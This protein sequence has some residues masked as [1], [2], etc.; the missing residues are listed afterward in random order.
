MVR[1]TPDV[2]LSS[3]RGLQLTPSGLLT[4]QRVRLASLRVRR[5]VATVLVCLAC[6]RADAQ[7]LTF[8]RDIAPIVFARCAPCHR[9]EGIGPFS[10]LTYQ[11]VNQRRSQIADVTARRVMPPWK[12]AP[13]PDAFVDERSLPAGE[14]AKLQQWIA[15]GAIEGEARDRPSPPEAR[16]GWELGTPDLI[17]TLPETYALQADGV[18]VFRT[19]VLPIPTAT[20]RYVR[21]LEF[22]PGNPRVIHHANLGIDRTRSSRRLDARDP[23][24]GY[25]GG[26]VLD[27]GYPPG[28]ML[29]WTPGQHARPS[30]EGMPWR[31]ERDSDLVAQ[32]HLQPTGKPE[33]VQISVGL[34]FADGPPARVPAGLR[35]GSETLDIAAGDSS[36][37]VADRYV[38][39][40]DVEL[41]AI[42]PHG[43][44]LL[45]RVSAEATLPDATT[46]RLIS[47]DDWDF[48]WQDVYRYAQPIALPKGTTISM[49]F[50]YDNSG[51]NPRNP[52]H[53]PERVVWG[54]NTS[55]EMGDLW[56]QL[57]PRRMADFAA[58]SADIARKQH[59]EDIAA[60]SKL[61]RE[62]PQNPHYRHARA[63]LLL[64]GGRGAEAVAEFQESLKLNPESAAGHYNVGLA[65][66]A[67]RR[68][69]EARAAFEEALRLVPDYAE[70]HNNLGAILHMM[71]RLD[72]AASHYG[73]AASLRPDNVEAEN[74][75]GRVL[76]QQGRHAEALDHYKRALTTN[77]DFATAL[78]GVAWIRATAGVSL[79][80]PREAIELSERADRLTG[81]QDAGVL[82]TLAASYAAAGSFERAVETARLAKQAADRAKLD[83]FAADIAARLALYERRQPYL[84]PV[85]R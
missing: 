36:Y 59:G 30:P 19:F 22:R 15:E 53:P 8:N 67:Q 47:I 79:R 4:S 11:D 3:R 29:G 81:H 7:T 35:M 68:F 74:N 49:R 26:M 75:L 27:A 55:D 73:L 17:V 65:L 80:D 44:N 37:L 69:D 23:G 28:Y 78:A 70:A 82:D 1:S 77:P 38:I 63:M 71:G 33:P 16:G 58:L 64:Q 9:P 34:F 54:Q 66:I 14:L 18:D 50:V 76:S 10:L 6:A 62:D 21:G 72:E 40:V 57:V 52:H 84:S 83:A 60:F 45:R 48:R 31:L 56:L 42:Q 24:P 85:M 43:H 32:L 12:P 51:F 5:V 25:S 13:M 41:L 2:L 61:V 39:P 20:P 46:R